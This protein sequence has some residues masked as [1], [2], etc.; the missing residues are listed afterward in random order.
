[1]QKQQYNLILIHEQCDCLTKKYVFATL[2][3]KT[4]KIIE[5]EERWKV[6]KAQLESTSKED[7]QL[8]DRPF[9]S[10]YSC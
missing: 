6:N 1:M 8:W 2:K 7:L 10:L 3:K 5:M 4:L 9:K